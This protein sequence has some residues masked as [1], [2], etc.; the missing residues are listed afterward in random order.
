M[1]SG[2]GGF[3]RANQ[4]LDREVRPFAL[5]PNHA[6]HDPRVPE[7]FGLT[8]NNS[9]GMMNEPMQVELMEKGE[10]AIDELDLVCKL[11]GNLAPMDPN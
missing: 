3:N 1:G 5:G 4:E 8:A 10:E 7:D 9:L 2:I 6:A 11:A